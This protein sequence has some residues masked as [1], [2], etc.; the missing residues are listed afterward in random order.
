M[1]KSLEITSNIHLGGD[2]GYDD[3]EQLLIDLFRGY[4]SLIRP[5]KDAFD[6]PIEVLFGMAMILLINV[7][8]RMHAN[9][10][11]TKRLPSGRKEPSDADERV[12][13]AQMA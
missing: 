10:P 6:L 4:N 9:Y 7:V 1:K 5:V 11:Q 2:L 13:N 12:A 3:E 8:R